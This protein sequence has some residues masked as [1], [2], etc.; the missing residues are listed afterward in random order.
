MPRLGLLGG[1]FDPVH[2]GHLRPAVEIK[3]ALELDELAFVP[4]RV[5][6]HRDHPAASTSQRLAMLEAAT[7]DMTDLRVDARELDRDGP[8]Y[9]LDTLNAIAAER[10]D[11]RLYL[12]IGA[13]AG[14]AFE[15]WHRWREILD[16]ANLVVCQ[17]PGW[18]STLPEGLAACRVERPADLH[19][20]AVGGV[21]VQA[22]TQLAISASGIRALAAAGGDLR[23]LLPEPVRALIEQHQLYATTEYTRP[24]GDR[25]TG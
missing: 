11:T 13:D 2:Y 10:P 15:R 12:I 24:D 23:Y 9:T 3:A 14:A 4:C 18:P 6:P 16:L 8:S 1:T 25:S 19:R 20:R 17:R 21:L 5:S 7:A 22:V